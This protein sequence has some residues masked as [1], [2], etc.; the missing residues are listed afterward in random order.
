MKE[1]KRFIIVGN[2]VAGMKA[3]EAIRKRNK[4][5]YIE[6][7]SNGEGL[8][9]DRPNLINM[10]SKE[11]QGEDFYLTDIKWYTK[12]NINLNLG[13]TITKI[14]PKKKIVSLDNSTELS[15]DKLILANGSE[16]RIPYLHGI[17]KEGIFTLRNYKDLKAIN[18]YLPQIEKVVIMGGSLLGLETA[19]KLKD[20]G[21]NVT[22]IESSNHLLSK[23]LDEDGSRL[24]ENLVEL[25]GIKYIIGSKIEKVIGDNS[26]E[27]V[28]LSNG[29]ILDC[30]MLFYSIGIKPNIQICDNT[31]IAINDGILVNNKMETNIESI[32]ACGDVAEFNG[33][34]YDHWH[35]ASKMGEIAGSNS[36]GANESFNEFIPY[37]TLSILN[38]EIFCYGVIPPNKSNTL[39][40]NEPNS[41]IYEKIFFNNNR[42]VAGI[43][44]GNTNNSS[45]LIE[46]IKNGLSIEEVKTLNVF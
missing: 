22:I 32:Y 38:T 6:I 29:N 16:N 15:Y 19:W 40:M 1:E 20:L 30:N 31:S 41:K 34:V 33:I 8:T 44:F 17:N 36:V 5:V 35:T 12:N 4:E 27:S 7:I 42:A 46:A 39:T 21:K 9:Y 37:S 11:C 18:N 25:N 23:Q 26:V 3:A 13:T 2:G 24:L 14:K 45:T 43:L 10:L 28:V